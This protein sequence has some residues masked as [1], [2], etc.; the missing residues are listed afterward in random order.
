MKMTIRSTA[1]VGIAG[2]IA[3][4]VV[5]T[6]TQL[7]AVGAAK[8]EQRAPA[9]RAPRRAE[10][11][12]QRALRALYLLTHRVSEGTSANTLFAAHSWYS[13]PPPPPVPAMSPAPA[14][15]PQVPTAPPLPFAFMG[16][17]TPDGT[18]PVFFL[19]QGDRVYNVRIGDTLDATYSV[20]SF[21]NGQL[22]LTYKPLKIQ[23]QLSVGGA[24]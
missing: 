11:N 4:Y 21:A 10:M 8:T 19:T 9:V 13:P 23:Q 1:L 15:V 2:S 12:G 22:V 16:S 7:Q 18:A 17:Y 14:A 24:P 6:P 5:F 3:A 20:D